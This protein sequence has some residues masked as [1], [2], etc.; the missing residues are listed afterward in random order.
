ME[1]P[2]FIN[3]PQTNRSKAMQWLL[4]AEKLLANRD[5]VGSKSFANGARESDP[6]LAP[7]ADR[8]LAIADILN[9]GD[10]RI[11]NEHFDYYSILQIPPNQTQNADFMAEQYRRFN[12]LL[13]P[14]NDNF[15]FSDQAFRL[16]VDAFTVLSDPLRKSMYDKELG[17]FLNPYPIVA[18]TPTPVHQSVYP[19]MPSSN[20]D[21][22]IMNFLTQDQGS[23][24]AGISFSEDPQAGISMPV[25]Y[26]THEQETVT[27]MASWHIE[28]QPQ[29]PVTFLRQQTQPVTSISFLNTD[30]PPATFLSLNQPQ[31]VTS[32][33]SLNRGNPQFGMG[34]G[35][36]QGQE[37]VVTVEQHGNQQSPE[38]NENVVGVNANKSASTGDNVKE[39]EGNVDASGKRIPSFWTAC[40][41]CLFMYE[42]SLDYTNCTL[43]CQNCKRG[44][45]AVPIASPPPVIDGKNS[46]FCCWG[47]MPFGLSLEDFD[48]NTDNSS[49]WSPFSPMF[50][51]PR[52]GGIGGSNVNNLGSSLNAG[53]SISGSGQKHF[54]PRICV[55]GDDAGVFFE[56][57]ESSE[58]SDVDWNRN[59]ER[60]KA[61]NVKRKSARTGTPRK[62]AKKQHTDK[63]KTV[64]GNNDGN[65][66]D[67][68]A[69]EGG[70]EMPML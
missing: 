60:K 11:N 30:E 38:R 6:T 51:S 48:R 35:S 25:T 24:A 46:S 63:A 12:F 67:G 65:L 29:Q 32:V 31:P 13:K 15:P 40:P 2:Y 55:Y 14:Q 54:A 1:Y 37:P 42:Y 45:Q 43:R 68:L 44:F 34:L 16:V 47:F 70:V 61:K 26:L 9:A 5:L 36:T 33:R 22:M 58:D 28:Q 50:T 52:F 62:K 18:S 4:T 41:Y 66:Q 8:I 69:T 57:S 17:F 20:A 23:H 53:G 10:K 19:S 21:Q 59:K 27:S 3:G 39:K 64:E 7:A 56:A 49:R